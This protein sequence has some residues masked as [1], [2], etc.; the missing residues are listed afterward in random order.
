MATEYSKYKKQLWR[1]FARW[2]KLY[3][4]DRY[5]TLKG[6][7]RLMNACVTCGK[8]S[9]WNNF[10]AGHFRTRQ[11]MST[12]VHEQN[13][14]PQC[15]Y[16]NKNDGEQY[17]HGLRID[18][19]YGEGTAEM[20]TLLQ[21]ETKKYAAYELQELIEHYKAEMKKIMDKWKFDEKL[22]TKLLRAYA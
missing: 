9:E 4:A 1:I 19:M 13:V 2:V 22:Q 14:H 3:H 12:F 17:K 21:N 18:E 8:E 7:D 5:S 16:C 6:Y 11:H 15:V 20:L 10:D